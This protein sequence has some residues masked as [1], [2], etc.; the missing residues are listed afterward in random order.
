VTSRK[1]D[2]IVLTIEIMRLAEAT[3]RGDVGFARLFSSFSMLCAGG[4]DS[5]AFW[6]YRNALKRGYHAKA[7]KC[8]LS[9]W[10]Q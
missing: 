8:G 10:L 7:K 6:H 1:A 9:R 2:A 3:D 4:G 5:K